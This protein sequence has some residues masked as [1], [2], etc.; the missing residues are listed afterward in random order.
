MLKK[1][2][3]LEVERLESRLVP[4]LTA[5][6]INGSLYISGKPNGELDII[7]TGTPYQ[8]RVTDNGAA[9]SGPTHT[10]TGNLLVNLQ[11]TKGDIKLDLD[12]E[13]IPGNV[14]INLGV[15]Y[16]GPLTPPNY[17][18]SIYDHNATG[19]IGGLGTGEI[20]GSVT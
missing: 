4:A 7:G 11:Y 14:L 15:G 6:N 9:V 12:G 2:I 8:F 13:T 19:A 5:T 3:W 1:R 16:V 17:S 10:I 18:V 20:S